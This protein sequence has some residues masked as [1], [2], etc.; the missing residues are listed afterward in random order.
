MA[1]VLFARLAD[2]LTQ[3]R[4]VVLASVV[5]AR[6]STP[7]ERAARMLIEPDA[8][9]SS[10]GGGAMEAR[11]LAAA[12][13]MLAEARA[14]EQLTITL[15]G[16]AD[17]AGVCGGAMVIGLRRWQ[18]E[19]MARRAAGIAARLADG[20][21]DTLSPDELGAPH[22]EPQALH[23][24][25]RLLILGAG[26]CGHALAELAGFLEFDVVVADS[27]PHCFEPGRYAGAR[28]IAA[29]ADSLR[30]AAVT[31]RDLY[32]VLLNR[33]YPTDVAAL[34][35]LAG[36]PYTFLGMM[37]S[38]RRIQQV[39]QALSTHTA[40]LERIV[41]PVG[42]D[43]GEQ[44]PHEIAVSILAQLIGWRA[45]PR[46]LPPAVAPRSCRSP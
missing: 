2:A 43:L 36:V 31:S 19:A 30:Q 11:V 40:W 10:V 32:L 13:C 22:A 12:R 28:C 24:R 21:R 44:T 46:R 27:R 17:S 23:P 1:E 4:A 29:D 26:H 15:D 6:G 45:Q 18:G 9:F 3:G 8:S 35:A 25:P 14:S 39:R 20:G 41:A 38:R 37:G 5:A 16:G 7:R 34:E 33:D 42:L